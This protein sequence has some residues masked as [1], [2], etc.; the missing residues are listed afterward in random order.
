MKAK[1]PQG[2]G[3]DIARDDILAFGRF[4]KSGSPAPDKE[5]FLAFRKADDPFRIAYK[6]DMLRLRIMAPLWPQYH[7]R[8]IV[9]RQGALSFRTQKMS[10]S[11]IVFADNRTE[12]LLNELPLDCKFLVLD[13]GCM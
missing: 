2:F 8:E 4:M 13:E 1:L 5:P 11:R 10:E 12:M 9:V 6:R 7:G 3:N